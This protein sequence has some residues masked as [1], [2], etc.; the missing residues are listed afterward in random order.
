MKAKRSL[1]TV[2]LVVALSFVLA[3]AA[4]CGKKSGETPGGNTGPVTAN[5]TVTFNTDGATTANTV[6]GGSKV[7]KPSDPVKDGYAFYGWYTDPNYRNAFN[8]DTLIT[9]NITLYAR[10]VPTSVAADEFQITFVS[11]GEVITTA[12]TEDGV[13][14][15]F[16]SETGEGFV[17]WWVSDYESADMLTYQ[18]DGRQL[19]QNTTFFA[20]YSDGA[21]TIS[22]KTSGISWSGMGVNVNYVVKVT[23]T[24]G[25][26][27]T[28]NTNALTF[29]YG[30]ADREAGDYVV[31]V[32]A[33]GMT[34]SAYFKNKALA[35]V[36]HFEV[37]GSTLIFNKVDNAAKYVLDIDCGNDEHQHDDVEITGNVYDFINCDMQVG[38]IKFNVTAVGEGYAPATSEYVFEQNLEG[39]S[40][41]VSDDVVSW[42]AVDNASS[43]TVK[44]ETADSVYEEFVG[45]DTSYSLKNYSGNM[46]VTVYAEAKGYNPAASAVAYNKSKLAT[47]AGL[48]ITAD[49]FTWDAVDGAKGYTVKIN[50]N[51]Y[52]TNSPSFDAS[53]ASLSVIG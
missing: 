46:T 5:Y 51:E 13:V 39:L 27:L 2:L 9:G 8:F 23:D 22:I 53:S 44:I 36:S 29:D 11:N 35:R 25:N 33:N 3:F 21:P 32:T 37:D 6:S 41:S 24:Y 12:G 48:K 1:I 45:T 18:Y 7:A 14:T 26:T 49:S 16:P 34:S 38:G 20:V 47:P 17:G 31:T 50:N 15:A 43:Y 40:A 19:K 42:N 30:F 4:S 10:L 28:R 52:K